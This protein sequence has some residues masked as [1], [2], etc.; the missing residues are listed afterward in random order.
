MSFGIFKENGV[1]VLVHLESARGVL[2]EVEHISM[3]YLGS[4]KR[5]FINEVKFFFI[6]I[7]LVRVSHSPSWPVLHYVDQAEC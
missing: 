6:F 4:W 1:K 3:Q 2:L 7:F 5:L